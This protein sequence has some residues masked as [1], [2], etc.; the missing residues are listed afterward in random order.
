[1]RHCWEQNKAPRCRSLVLAVRVFL[2]GRIGAK[3]R[4]PKLGNPGRGLRQLH[5]HRRYIFSPARTP[6][7]ASLRL[8][9]QP[10]YRM[11]LSN[12]S[13]LH[14]RRQFKWHVHRVRRS[15][16]DRRWLHSKPDAGPSCQSC[17]F[18]KTRRTRPRHGRFGFFPRT[19]AGN[20]SPAHYPAFPNAT[21]EL[22]VY[23]SA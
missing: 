6:M 2:K 10:R 18:C 3:A 11:G 13:R 15:A 17:L 23:S 8:P 9:R 12:A 7:G 5:G 14:P 22:T 20:L 21:L 16:L 19:T 1:M 4:A